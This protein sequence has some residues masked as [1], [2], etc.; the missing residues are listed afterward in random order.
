MPVLFKDTGQVD[1]TVA[2]IYGSDQP[3]GNYVLGLDAYEANVADQFDSM[4][5]VATADDVAPGTA[6]TAIEGVVD[7]YPGAK[8][9]DP[10]GFKADPPRRSTSCS[11]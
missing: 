4:V 1:L 5:F 10:A 3:A 8:L 7:T 2:V 9:L 6:R 11:A